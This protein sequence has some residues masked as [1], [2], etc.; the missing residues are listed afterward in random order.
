MY[1]YAACMATKTISID[2]EAYKRLRQAR[3]LPNESFSQVIRRAV[4]PDQG[5]TCGAFLEL[6]DQLPPMARAA[7]EHLE[8]AQREDRAP[9]DP[10]QTF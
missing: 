6:W 1:V 10:W 5:R 7:I 9:E 8:K 3:R 4:W 2:L